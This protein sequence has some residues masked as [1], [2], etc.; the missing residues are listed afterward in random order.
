[1]SPTRRSP[2]FP[3]RPELI[4]IVVAHSSNRVIGRAGALPWRLPGDMRHFRRLTIGHTVLMGRLT[5]QS[6]PDRFRPLP[7]RRNLVLSSDPHFDAAGAEVFASLDAA[8]SAADGDCFVIGGAVTYEEAMPL[9]S[10]LYATEIEAEIDGDVYLPPIGEGWSCVEESARL[11]ENDLAYR[12]R[13]YE[14]AAAPL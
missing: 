7:E 12:F 1:M 9:A 2:A 8:L 3:W 14:R 11:V 10:R 13:I 6:L 5:F 4:A